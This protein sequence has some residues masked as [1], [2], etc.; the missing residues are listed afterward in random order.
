[1][2]AFYYK[3]CIRNLTQTD[4]KPF[5]HQWDENY[6]IFRGHRSLYRRKIIN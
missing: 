1:M 6:N 4:I 3:P 2:I 5:L